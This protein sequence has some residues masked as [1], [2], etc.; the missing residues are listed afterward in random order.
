LDIS[1]SARTVAHLSYL[2][3]HDLF[4]CFT[5][6]RSETLLFGQGYLSLLLFLGRLDLFN[7]SE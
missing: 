7:A 6:L 4:S 2:H 3:A 1:G 5:G